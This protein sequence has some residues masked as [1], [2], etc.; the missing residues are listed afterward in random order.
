MIRFGKRFPLAV[1]LSLLMFVNA[2][3]SKEDS[4]T[5]GSKNP[6]IPCET[7][8]PVLLVH[9][10]GSRDNMFGVEY[11][12]RIPQ[13]LTE[14]CKIEV[15]FGG[16]DAFGMSDTNSQQLLQT[17]LHITDDLG[18]EKVNIIAHSKGGLDSRFMF[19]L[20]KGKLINGRTLNDRV[21]SLTTLSTPHRGSTL[22]D[23][24]FSKISDKV[25][26]VLALVLSAFGRLQGDSEQTDAKEALD[27]LTHKTMGDWNAKMGDL[28]TGIDGV[29]SQSWSAIISGAISDPVFKT[30]SEIMKK[31]GSPSNDGA[32]DEPSAV[33]A[34]YR[35]SVGSGWIGGVSH[36]AIVDRAQ[37]VTPGPTP[38]FD[39]RK[40]YQSILT[41][42]AT[43]GF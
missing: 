41:E 4:D 22:A 34:N 20:N 37:V 30:T 18:F 43:K 16:Q 29:Y 14:N 21:S 42:L 1:F 17:V 28:E 19:F 26:N 38:G 15:F 31:A 10:V 36:M 27:L 13:Y 8:Y 2:C 5:A 7:K 39:P 11:F 24:L 12:G 32:V 3:G 23:Y 40:F 25:E 9:G 6:K 35:G 33:Y